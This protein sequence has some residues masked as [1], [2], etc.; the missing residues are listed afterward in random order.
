MLKLKLFGPGEASFYDQRLE[1]FPYQQVYLLFCYLLINKG[2]T[3]HR[4]RLATVFWGDYPSLT[5]RKYLR[6]TLYRLRQT[7]DG[8]GAES[9]QYFNITEDNVAFNSTSPYWLDIESFDTITSSYRHYKAEDFLPEQAD[10]LGKCVDLYTGD[11]LESV[12]EDWCLYD[13]ERLR[14]AYL[15]ALNKLM[16]YMAAHG[17]YDHGIQYGER[18]LVLDPARENVHRQMMVLHWLVGDR[19]SALVQYKRCAQILREEMGIDPMGETRILYEQMVH[20]QFQPNLTPD[21]YILSTASDAP[22]L[23]TV[24]DLELILHS[25]SNL[26]Q[27]AIR[28]NQEIQQIQSLIQQLLSKNSAQ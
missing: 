26:E 3:H 9:S 23:Y 12:Y 2:K 24:T 22:P 25:L 27:E 1:G 4:E 17:E 19:F 15:D 21:G 16:M 13:R 14:L 10:E 6:N 8:V 28:L 20:N 7:L 11:L 5:A 18:I